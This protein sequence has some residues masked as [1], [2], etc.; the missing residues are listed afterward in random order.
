MH[1]SIVG[2]GGREKEEEIWAE[3]SG[4]IVNKQSSIAD[5]RTYVGSING[6][7]IY[8]MP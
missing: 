5:V 2:V 6:M 1:A 8:S 4:G 3:G 7:Q